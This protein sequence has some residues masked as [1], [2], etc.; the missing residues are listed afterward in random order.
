VEGTHES[1][2]LNQILGNTATGKL[3]ML[4]MPNGKW[5]ESSEEVIQNLLQTHFPGCMVVS[6]DTSPMDNIPQRTRWILSYSW[7][8]AKSLITEDRIKWAFESMAHINLQVR[9]EFY[10]FLCN[11]GCSMLSHLFANYTG[12]HSLLGIFR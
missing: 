4:R 10:L 8:I 5:T 2:R 12:R 6:E 9:M 3:G 11:M 7:E 1:S